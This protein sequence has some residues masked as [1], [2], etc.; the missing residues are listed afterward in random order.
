MAGWGGRDLPWFNRE[1]SLEG[2]VLD[3]LSNADDVA[4][5]P[6]NG[7]D[8]PDDGIVDPVLDVD[9]GLEG[10]GDLGSGSSGVGGDYA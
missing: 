3:L 7:R 9:E 10:H 4:A 1:D 8:T 6:G 2:G 5:V